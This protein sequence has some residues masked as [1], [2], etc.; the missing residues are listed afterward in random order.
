VKTHR[1]DHVIVGAGIAGIWLA[2]RL[3]SMG[4]SV[5]M[6]E[7]GPHTPDGARPPHP[8]LHF[9]ERENLGAV[10]ARH[11]ALTGN[12]SFWGGALIRNDAQSLRGMF[13]LDER[14]GVLE[15]FAR[16]YDAVEQQLD[17]PSLGRSLLE[18]APHPARL[19]EVNVLPGRQRNLART[20]LQSCAGHP[21]FKLLCPAEVVEFDIGADGRIEAVTALAEDGSPIVLRAAH[22]VLSAGVIDSNILALTKLATALDGVHDRIGTCLHDHWSI[23]IARFRWKR[24]AGV[25]WLYPPTFRK[26]YIQGR[27][28]EFDVA[29][30]RGVHSGF[31]HVQAQYDLV[32]P[33]A[34]I[35][36][37]M[38]ARQEGQRWWQQARFLLPLI[39]HSPHMV[40]IGH[41]RFIDGRL[42]VADG[43]ELTVVM[44]FESF[45][46]PL[47]RLTFENGEYRLHWDVREQDVAAFA[48][49]LPRGIDLMMR[50]MRESGLDLELLAD[51]DQLD[52]Q[53]EY[54]RTHAVDAYHLGGGLAVRRDLERGLLAPDLRFHKIR[55]L[56]VISTAAFARPGIANPVETLLAMCE[57]YARN[58]S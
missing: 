54:I 39:G 38:N 27:R 48:A 3:L 13:D 42:F 31:L 7:I 5:A 17:A 26:G 19:A 33:Y 32:E 1:A 14:E 52:V 8:P 58:L 40:R 22:Y 2:R 36:K 11:H 47:N 51:S 34:T 23:P 30:P 49:L 20:V 29:L 37:W 24:G 9:P 10:Q 35:K 46:S 28:V 4:R 55:N 41:S 56:A 44:D 57:T 15:E 12:S 21:G 43:M 50:W 6:I 45:P 18:E 25:E 53:R 16:S